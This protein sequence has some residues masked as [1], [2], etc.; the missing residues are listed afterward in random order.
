VSSKPIALEFLRKVVSDP[1]MPV[2]ARI[3]AARALAPYEANKR[4]TKEAPQP[5]D[6][7]AASLFKPAKPPQ[8]TP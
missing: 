3:S 7:T 1:A 5:E 4:P 6:T 8:H 2:S